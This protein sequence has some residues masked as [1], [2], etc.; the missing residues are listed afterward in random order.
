LVGAPP[1]EAVKEIE[2][3]PEMTVGE[4]KKIIRKKFNL[5]KTFE[6]NLVDSFHNKKD[7]DFLDP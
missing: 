7:N 6:L 2:I 5:P 1:G 3:D 4:V